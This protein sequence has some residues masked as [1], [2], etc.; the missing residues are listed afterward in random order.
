VADR[1]TKGV[2]LVAGRTVRWG[3]CGTGKIAGKFAADLRFV[4]GAELVAVGSRS[5]E[6]AEIFTQQLPGVRTYS[7]YAALAADDE[8]DVVYVATPQSRHCADTLLFLEA[9]KAVLCEKPFAMSVAESRLMVEAARSAG[10]LL[11][12][13]M[14]MR[15][16]PLHRA[17]RDL[18]AEGAIGTP[19]VLSADFG[20]RVP[21]GIP[22]RLLDRGL[23]GGA[24]LDIGIYPVSLASM[25]FG[26]PTEVKALSTDDV[27][28]RVDSQTAAV[29]R[30]AGGAL[31]VL[32]S[33]ILGA[34]PGVASLTGSAG[35]ITVTRPFHS[36]SSLTLESAGEVKELHY[37][38]AGVGLHFQATEV[39][40]C[41]R[42]GRIESD[43]M[44]WSETL[45]V[46]AT[47]EEIRRQTDI[48]QN[49]DRK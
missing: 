1:R 35:R 38:F 11:V 47:V 46:M 44:P 10:V 45:A 8:V 48:F 2:T 31:A 26:S 14:W 7:E 36:G 18:V 17:L 28:A 42:A 13:A 33:S 21:P 12:E 23:G 39:G 34:T 15:F 27:D 30:Y 22:H 41:L 49:H 43:I 9:G 40:A 4:E 32:Y 6:R 19:H 24:L 29:L 3:I 5:R 37:P 25:L 20:Y 16:L